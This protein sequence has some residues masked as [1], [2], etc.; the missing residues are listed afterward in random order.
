MDTPHTPLHQVRRSTGMAHLNVVRL[1][2]T[3]IRPQISS[4]DIARMCFP[5]PVPR[6]VIRTESPAV[7]VVTAPNVTDGDDEASEDDDDDDDDTLTPES[8]ASTFSE[9][10]RIYRAR[11]YRT[12][13][14]PIAV[15]HEEGHASHLNMHASGDQGQVALHTRHLR[16]VSPGSDNMLPLLPPQQPTQTL[17]MSLPFA[18]PP[19]PST[20]IVPTPIQ[21]TVEPYR[22]SRP[23]AAPWRRPS[24]PPSPTPMPNARRRRPAT[25]RRGQ[26]HYDGRGIFEDPPEPIDEDRQRFLNHDP[27]LQALLVEWNVRNLVQPLEDLQPLEP[28]Q[29][30]RRSRY[31]VRRLTT[32]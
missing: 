27:G 19:N 24:P 28:P 3:T 16:D 2:P 13:R 12:R 29:A 14:Q 4:E 25:N 6:Q 18:S 23:P 20:G 31:R 7:E 26:R 15:D 32:P 1:G 10:G 17:P 8:H 9:M 22:L 30:P 21:T 5:R 11:L